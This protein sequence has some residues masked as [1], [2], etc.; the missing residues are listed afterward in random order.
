MGNK[1]RPLIAVNSFPDAAVLEQARFV[2][3]ELK[4]QYTGS[5]NKGGSEYMPSVGDLPRNVRYLPQTPLPK[6]LPDKPSRVGDTEP[7]LLLC[8]TS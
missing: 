2:P 1:T 3:L 6:V 5:L 4:R 7:A 8:S